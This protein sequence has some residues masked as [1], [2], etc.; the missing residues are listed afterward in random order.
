MKRQRTIKKKGSQ[1]GEGDENENEECQGKGIQPP[2]KKPYEIWP[3]ITK[4][5]W[6]AFVARKTTAQGVVSD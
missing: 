6:E 4:D 5:E 2:T 1:N 3:H